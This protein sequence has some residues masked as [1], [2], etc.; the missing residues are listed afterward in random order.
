M[1]Y[2]E[3]LPIAPS[4]EVAIIMHEDNSLAALYLGSF[5]GC[6]LFPLT[7]KYEHDPLKI[8]FVLK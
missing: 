8:T 3:T 7:K 6:S 1:S 4:V 5:T 2:T